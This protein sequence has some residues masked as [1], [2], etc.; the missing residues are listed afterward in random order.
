MPFLGAEI[1]IVN[2]HN[3]KTVTAL[4]L[5]PFARLSI[6]KSFLTVE[7]GT[8]GCAMKGVTFVEATA[9]RWET[10]YM[11]ASH[12]ETALLNGITHRRHDCQ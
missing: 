3:S 7:L 6:V 4:N 9:S 2:Y 5:T 12:A 8:V 10:C 1:P 11:D